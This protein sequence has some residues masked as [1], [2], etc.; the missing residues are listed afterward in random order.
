MADLFDCLQ[1]AM[2]AGLVDP[3]R[4]TAAQ[5]D[6]QDLFERYRRHAPDAAAAAMAA[7]DV[8][9]SVA[10][11]ATSRRHT[12]LAQLQ[13][14]RANQHFVG[15][16]E[17]PDLAVKS[18]LE[19]GEGRGHAQEAVRSTRDAISRQLRGMIPEF[20]KRNARDLTGRPRD[21]ALLGDVVRELHGEG[22]GNGEAA[23]MA[24]AVQ[25]A[26]ERARTLFNAHGG[27]I[28]ELEDFGLP[29]SHDPRRLRR[30]GFDAWR[31]E[32]Q[33]R[34][35]WSRIIDHQTD[36]P[37]ASSRGAPP[38]AAAADRF[39]RDIYSNLTTHGWDDRVPSLMPGG[40]AL[41]N[42]RAEHRVLH[43][44]D[45]S[46]WL[47]YN[48]AFGQANPFDAIVAH[49]DGMARDIA[50]MRVLGPNPKAGLEHAI[51]TAQRV[52]SQAADP[53]AERRV[54]RASVQARA[55]LAHLTGSANDPADSG[56]AAFLAGT[57]N[58]L[59]AAQLGSAL[60]S[61]PT[62]LWTQ[63]MAARAVGIGHG[64]VFARFV[65]L[66]ASGSTRE[67]AARMGY[68]A[69]T[70]ADTGST[71][72]RYLG[73]VWSPEITE[74]LASGVMRASGLARWTD[75][76]RLAFQMEFAGLLAEQAGR[77]LDQVDEPLRSILR[78]RGFDDAEWTRLADPALHFRTDAG[79][80]FL[81][82]MHWREAAL[83]AGLENAEAEGLAIRLQALIEEQ[84]EFAVPSVSLDARTSLI[85]E[86]P[87]GTIYGELI[88]STAMYKNFALSLTLNQVRRTMARP[89]AMNRA[90]YAAQL[91]AGL[92]LL[93]G[94]SV[95]LKEVAKGRDPRPMD[96]PA[97]WGAAVFQGGGL[98]I[99]GDFF[100]ASTSRAGGGFAET[101]AG[102]VVGL[103]AD[104]ARAV[105][106]NADRAAQG[107]A[108]LIGRDAVNLARRYTPG[109]SLWYGRL[110]LD[111]LVWDQLQ[112][113]LDPEARTLWRRQERKALRDRGNA[114]W[115]RKGETAPD[116]APSFSSLAGDARR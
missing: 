109:S 54:K 99:F 30:A 35:D 17:R 49:L 41:A 14:M 77:T 108:P 92:T 15:Q 73:D 13:R 107:K 57:R 105:A 58:V 45:A 4:G 96:D 111:R 88:R 21:R 24:G 32:I 71:A 76:N 46:S 34:L 66:M 7:E 53:V 97:F 91:M 40:A 84:M 110:A 56:M 1:S 20:L 43:F 86:A 104:V 60:L 75:M 23:R 106:S 67:T 37:F 79:E 68:I 3:Q 95:Q 80:T 98:G 36:R 113:M 62:D 69:D 100:S 116:R 114:A 19:R 81:A 39:L 11:A 89:G 70:L 51:Q 103:G 59:T 18:L 12:V 48:D 85:G 87:P 5:R 33:P 90:L 74:R 6:Y 47:A 8:K 38:D 42:R 101:L 10:R 29:H 44:R 63:H 9:K 102:P 93:G 22:S 82:P 72:A 55:M 26:F 94:V 50:L 28:G 64:K 61:A 83:A 27:D 2:D 52:A 25:K 16:A 31:A 112:D 115:W 65:S 78:G